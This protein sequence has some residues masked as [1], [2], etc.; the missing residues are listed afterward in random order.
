MSPVLEMD[1]KINLARASVLL[2]ESTT[3]AVD[4]LGQIVKGFGVRDVFRCITIE[5]A[6]KVVAGRTVDLVV[7]EPNLREGDG[8][9]FIN[10]LRHSKEEPNCYAPIIMTS[11]PAYASAVGRTRDTGAN[12]YV[13]KPIT[14]LVLLERIMWIARDKRPFVDCP[15]YVGPERRFKFEG[16]PPGCEG[17]RASDV[18]D[19]IGA[20]VAPNLSQDE[21]STMIK[22][23]RVSL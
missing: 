7:I 15:A 11:G 20:A 16:P 13:A 14:P 8:Y 3:H 9:G 12:F 22:P 19:P 21:I 4:L 18:K 6:E 23:Q 2:I 17:R 10:R 1:A 5:E